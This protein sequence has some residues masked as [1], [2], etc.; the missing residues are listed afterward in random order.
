MAWKREGHCTAGCGKC[1]LGFTLTF[2]RVIERDLIKYYQ[3]HGV[4][5]KLGKDETKL[6]FD[7]PCR[8]LDQKTMLCKLHGNKKPIICMKYP[9]TKDRDMLPPECTYKFVKE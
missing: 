1:C 7:I 3:M 5:V 4:K 2:T 8:N 9:E 6:R